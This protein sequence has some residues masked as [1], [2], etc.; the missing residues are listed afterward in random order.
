MECNKCG[1]TKIKVTLD[2][3][4]L[5]EARCAD[6]G[7][8]IKKMKMSEVVEYYQSQRPEPESKEVPKRMPCKYCTENYVIAR[9]N[10]RVP[11]QYIPIK[12]NYC[13]MCGRKLEES[14]RDY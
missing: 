5:A 12:A 14:D 9:G 11:R 8:L 13:P 3:R 7:S 6:C 1:C 10:I 2:S 4:G